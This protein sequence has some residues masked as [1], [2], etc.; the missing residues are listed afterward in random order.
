MWQSEK[1]KEKFQ[2]RACV[3]L[4]SAF[5]L[6]LLTLCLTIAFLAWFALTRISGELK[7]QAMAL[8]M[9]SSAISGPLSV[10]RSREKHPTLNYPLSPALVIAT[11]PP[12]KL[13]DL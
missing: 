7:G 3:M 13:G 6:I 12:T 10:D 2:R 1:K 8:Y 11:S 5:L 4:G 9:S